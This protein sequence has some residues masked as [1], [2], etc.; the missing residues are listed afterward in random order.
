MRSTATWP[1]RRAGRATPS[2]SSIST[3]TWC[4]AARPVRCELLDED[5]FE[6]HRVRFGYPDDVVAEARAAAR[7]AGRAR[8]RHRAVRRRTAN[9]CAGR[10]SRRGSARWAV[11]PPRDASGRHHRGH[12][13]A[14]KSARLADAGGTRVHRVIIVLLVRIGWW[15][16]ERRG[17]PWP[18]AWPDSR[19]RRGAVTAG[20]AALRR[21]GPYLPA[22]HALTGPG[23]RSAARRA[24]T[25]GS[26]DSPCRYGPVRVASSSSD[27]ATPQPGRTLRRLVLSPLFE[28]AGSGAAGCG[29]TRVAVPAGRRV[30]RTG[31]RPRD[32]AARVPHAGPQ[33]RDRATLLSRCV[34]GLLE[35]GAVTV[36]VAGIVDV[37]EVLAAQRERYVFADGGFDDVGDPAAPPT[38]VPMIS[39]PWRRRFGWDGREP[40]PA[41][42]R[43]LL[44]ALV[45]AAHQDGRTVRIGDVPPR[46]SRRIRRRSGTELTAAGV[47]AIADA[48]HSPRATGAGT[49]GGRQPGRAGLRT[50]PSGPTAAALGA[51]GASRTGPPRLT[52][53]ER[54]LNCC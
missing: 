40:I 10:S 54:G 52:T 3:W 39:E 36:S 42:E 51:P 15:R 44:H 29:G 17:R 9:G 4:A 46:D 30:R 2:T 20:L 43:H 27:P 26:P 32:P 12:I 50:D 53:R 38:L 8:R 11:R 24:A 31:P 22:G 19:E 49:A 47:D 13:S 14:V 33:L 37:R 41:E 34:G 1:P 16:S 21:R 18:A 7:D 45:R 23:H 6:E 35:P 28:R 5:E 25:A 48:D